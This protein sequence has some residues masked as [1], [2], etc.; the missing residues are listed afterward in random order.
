VERVHPA[1]DLGAHHNAL[2]RHA[3]ERRAAAFAGSLMYLV[4][5]NRSKR[6]CSS[7]NGNIMITQFSLRFG[8]FA[9]MTLTPAFQCELGGAFA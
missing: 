8:F 2:A 3:P 1:A 4:R 5:S 7:M 9:C 6:F